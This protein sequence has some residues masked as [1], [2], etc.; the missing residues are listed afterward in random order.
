MFPSPWNYLILIFMWNWDVICHLCVHLICRVLPH[1]SPPNKAFAKSLEHLTT[2][3]DLGSRKL[4]ARGVRSQKK[5]K[6]AST[7]M[8]MPYAISPMV[9]SA[10]LSSRQR[11]RQRIQDPS[12]AVLPYRNGEVREP[13]LSQEVPSVVAEVSVASLSAPSKR[14]WVPSRRGTAG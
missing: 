2:D 11:N 4:K 9:P 7:V 5:Q 14:W 6:N 1:L 12:G 3:G 13:G 10:S 8:A